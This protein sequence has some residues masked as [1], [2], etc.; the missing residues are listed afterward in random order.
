MSEDD[1]RTAM[2]KPWVS[3]ASDAE[4]TNPKQKIP[5]H[6]RAY[7]TF[8]RVLGR[9]VRE[10]KV[11]VLE[12][13]IRKM[14]SLPASQIGLSDRGIVRQGAFADLV[15]FDPE[16]VRDT[17]TFEAAHSYPAGID[18]VVVNGTVTIES[19]EHTGARAG[20]PVRR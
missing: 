5:V 9:Y 14:T 20:R 10:D 17:A 4:A 19:G 1:V 18:Y 3:I 12:E 15:V 7:G 6:P 8:P 11:L 13:A 16:N 2:Q